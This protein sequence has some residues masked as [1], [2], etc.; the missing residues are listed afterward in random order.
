MLKLITGGN[1][2]DREMLFLNAVKQSAVDG[3]DVLVV[4]PDQFSFEYDKKLYDAMGAK[5]FNKIQTAG[6]NRLAE[7]IAK[8]YG[9]DSKNNADNNAV[10]ITMYK[11]ICRLKDTDDVRFYKKALGKSSFLSEVIDLISE[12]T[13]SRITAED[14]RIASENTDGLLSMK[15]FDIS[16]LFEYYSDE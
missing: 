3:K 9:G 15:L 1:R 13:R 11:A 6:F 8:K 10:I 4:I 14:L 5:Y 12:L 2:S 16:R 7:L